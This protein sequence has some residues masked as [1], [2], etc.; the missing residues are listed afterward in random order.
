MPFARTLDAATVEK[1]LT[2]PGARRILAACIRRPQPVKALSDQAEIPL[3]SAYRQVNALVES[4]ML[5]VERSALTRD[6]KPYDLYRSRIRRGR[7]EVAP[8]RVQV[9]W[10]ANAAVEDR[11]VHLWGQIR[12]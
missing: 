9:T 2:N 7:I 6:G 4:G 5:I 11:L 8:D 10:E 3:A 1:A 12:S